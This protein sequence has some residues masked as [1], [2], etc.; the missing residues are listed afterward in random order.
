MTVIE[1]KR[2]IRVYPHQLTSDLKN[3]ILTESRKQLNN[4]CSED[5]GYII[6]ILEVS[7]LLDNYIE[8]S[9]SDIVVVVLLLADV[10]RPKIDDVEDGKVI[11]IYADGTLMEIRDVQKILIPTSTYSSEYE[12]SNDMLKPLK[13]D[14]SPIK[15]GDV[16]KIKIKAMRYND[17]AFSC[18]G[19]FNLKE[20]SNYN[21]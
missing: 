18:I 10:F 19:E 8:N 13:P 5:I 11:A 12:F 15:K 17:H 6:N 4:N 14:T 3:T 20:N 2:S 7:S 21:K 9:S 16:V 1:L